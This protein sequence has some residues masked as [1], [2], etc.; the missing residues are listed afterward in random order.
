MLEELE[1]KLDSF[2]AAERKQALSALFEKVESGRITLPQAGT[3][4]NL[5]CHTFFS[6]NS[7][8][9]SPSKFAWLARK[10]GLAV[11]GVVDFDVL[12]ALEEF[13]AAARKLGLKACAG[14]ETRVFVPEFSTRIINSPGEPGISYHM[15]VGFPKAGL[16][17]EPGEFLLNLR[18]TAQKRNRDLMGRV[19]KYLQ[20]VE[21]DYEHDVLVLTPSGNATERHICLAYARK[22]KEVFNNDSDLSQFWAEKLG[23]KAESLELPESVDLLNMIRA[24]TMKRGGMG[25]IVPNK[26]SFPLM[27]GFNRFVLA[28]GGI[29]TMTWLNGLSDGE[30]A[31]EELV[32]VT[33]RA[34]A[35]A[36]NIIPDRNYTPGVKNQ[37]L[38]NLYRVVELAEKLH[39]PVV[40]G[41]EMNS[42]GQKFV[43]DFDS[44]EL[45]PLL[46]VFLKGAYIVYAHS[47]LQQRAGLGY[48]GN[49]AKK[50]FIGL[51]ERNEF[52]R[53]I[54]NSLEPQREDI[55]AD[56]SEDATAQQ[57]LDKVI[58]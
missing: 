15:G 56:F 3:A 1:R 47:V 22:A 7:Y 37:K 4:V 38:E 43:D 21:L 52:F 26:G 31:I 49:W 6:Y 17:G 29:P 20:P 35:T 16:E 13:L 39:L 5:H 55:L 42:P 44:Q 51:V 24:K 48:N 19:N 50:N 18:K 25:Y 54:G 34:G 46:P 14:L 53:K 36:I 45:S 9:Y 30:Q 11:A 41:T 27:A 2:N 23:P 58:N 57:I 28:A 32:E 40:V 10:A 33:M 12:D 8:G